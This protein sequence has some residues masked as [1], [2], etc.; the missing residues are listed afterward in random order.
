MSITGNN[1]HGSTANYGTITG[2]VGNTNRAQYGTREDMKMSCLRA[3][4]A[5]LGQAR[6][7]MQVR[8]FL[9]TCKGE[10]T[11]GSLDWFLKTD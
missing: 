8:N 2:P 11:E 10:T 7:P 6:E 9:R 3:L 5:S 4:F 1:T